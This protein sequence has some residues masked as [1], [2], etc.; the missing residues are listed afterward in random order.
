M[1]SSYK[2][3]NNNNHMAAWTLNKVRTEN[4]KRDTLTT[5]RDKNTITDRI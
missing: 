1:S 4:G 2:N 5:K 3:N